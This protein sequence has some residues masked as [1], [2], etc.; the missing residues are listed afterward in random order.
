MNNRILF[1]DDDSHILASYQR[2]L[3]K[4]FTVDTALGGRQGLTR[5]ANRGPYA[6]V[7]SDLRMP[8]MDGVEFLCQVRDMNPDTVRIML[9]G[10]A[11]VENAIQAVNEGNIFRFLTKPCDPSVLSKALG[12]GLAHYRLVT[13]ERE[14]LEKTLKGSIR[15]L[16]E[17]LSLIN[18]EAFGRSSRIKRYV[19][20]ITRHMGVP[21]AWRLETAAMLSQVGCVILPEETL[22]KVYRG[23]PLTREESHLL[24]MHPDVARNLLNN[25]PRMKKIAEIVAFQNKRFDGSGMPPDPRGGEDIPLGARVLKVVLDF[26]LLETTGSSPGDAIEQLRKRQGWYD[27]KI[28]DS[29]EAVIR[30][31]RDG[32]FKEITVEELQENMILEKDVESIEGVLL[33]RKGHEVSRLLLERLR[34]FARGSRIKEPLR[35]RV[36]ECTEAD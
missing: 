30:K 2:Q 13:A 4:Q 22:D 7:V 10:Y 17:V 11:D 35:V 16:T 6:V 8:G 23:Q 20:D 9:T 14:L 15:V 25:I 31:E 28:L 33:V 26:D 32:E 5:V 27:P 24:E 1:V 21:D 18:P 19:H 34:N 3:R 36:V 12:A 29:L